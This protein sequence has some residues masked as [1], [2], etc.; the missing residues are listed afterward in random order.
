MAK[1]KPDERRPFPNPN[2]P[3][4]P[5]KVTEEIRKCAR[6]DDF[7]L[8]P[9]E[10]LEKRLEERGLIM[11]DVLNVLKNGFVYEDPEESTWKNLWKYKVDGRS[12]NSENRVLRLVVIPNPS[13]HEIKLVTIMW[14]DQ[15]VG[16]Y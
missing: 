13:T 14:V 12:P 6:A 16:G 2:G 11:G 9:T 15:P 1:Q 10:H 5:S 4:K 3:W 8:W 7:T